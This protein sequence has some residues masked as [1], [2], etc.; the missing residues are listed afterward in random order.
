MAELRLAL[1]AAESSLSSTMTAKGAKG[2]RPWTGKELVLTQMCP[3]DA[4]ARFLKCGGS[5]D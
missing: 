1:Q 4:E 2:R 5:E 3:I